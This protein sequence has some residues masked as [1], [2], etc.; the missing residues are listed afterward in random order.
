MLKKDMPKIDMPKIT[1]YPK[2]KKSPNMSG[3]TRRPLPNIVCLKIS[4]AKNRISSHVN[5]NIL[6]GFDF[7]WGT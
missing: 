5:E 7:Q 1:I 6:I 4:T 3:T 2:N